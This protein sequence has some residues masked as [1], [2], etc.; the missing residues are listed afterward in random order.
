VRWGW[1]GSGLSIAAARDIRAA[2][3]A[4]RPSSPIS[5]I[6]GSRPLASSG[7]GSSGAGGWRRLGGAIRTP[8]KTGVHKTP[9]S[10]DSKI[11]RAGKFVGRMI[12]TF[13][14]R[15]SSSSFA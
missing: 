5:T 14:W 4:K 6:A 8:P 15:V 13:A 7:I 2:L 10:P 12:S 1:T 11:P 9:V 3:D